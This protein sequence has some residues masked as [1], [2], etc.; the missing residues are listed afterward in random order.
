MHR[1]VLFAFLT[2]SI[3]VFGQNAGQIGNDQTVCYGSASQALSFT[4]QPSGGTIPYSYRWERSNDAGSHWY[5]ISGATGSRNVYSPPVLGRTAWFRCRVADANTV[6]LGVTNTVQITVLPDLTPGIIAGSQTMMYGEIPVPFY[7]YESASGGDAMYTYR[8]QISDNGQQWED[9]NGETGVEYAP[10]AMYGTRWFRRWVSDGSCGSVAGNS[11]MIGINPITLY[12]TETPVVSGNESVY[13]MGTEFAALRDG[14]ITRARLYTH[15]LE[16]GDHIVRIWMDD[17]QIGGYATIAGP[18]TWSITAGT[19]GWR[20]FELPQAVPVHAGTNYIV[21]ITNGTGNNWYVQSVDNFNTV[22]SNIYIDYLRGLYTSNPD[23]VPR[24]LSGGASFFRDVVFQLFTPGAVASDQSICYQTIPETL[25][26]TAPPEGGTGDYSYQWQVSPDSVTWTNID[27]AVAANYSPQALTATSYFR[28][29]ASSGNITAYSSPVLITV[30]QEFSLAQL[31]DDITIYNNT[32]TNFSIG[33]SGGTPPYTVAYDRNGSPQTPVTGYMSGEDIATG[34]LSTGSYTYS[35]TSVTDAAG[36]NATSTGSSITVTVSGTYVP[37]VTNKALV[38]VNSVSSDYDDYANY[39][40]PYL[41][42]FGV[43]AD[44]YNEPTPQNLPDLTDYA[45][46]ILGHRN[47]YDGVTVEYPVAQVTAAV[48]DGVGLVSFDPSFFNHTL[49]TLSSSITPVSVSSSTINVVNTSH[50]ITGYHASD[51]YN[52]PLVEGGSEYSNNYDVLTLNGAMS[53][54]QSTGLVGGTDL[55]TLS[56]SG[57]TASLVEVSGYGSGRIV[58]WN[59]Y[60]W[61]FE[62]VLGPVYGMDDI[63][64]RSIVWPARK[65]FVIKGM[66]PMITM[67]VDDVN[68]DG[69]GIS[70][71]F[72][73]LTISNEYGFVP[74]CGTFETIPAENMSLFRGLLN[75]NQATAAPHA[76]FYESSIYYNHDNVP[77]FDALQNTRDARAFYTTNALPMSKY[78][79]PHYYEIDPAALEGLVEMGIE[80]IGTHMQIGSPYGAAWLQAGPYRINRD[81]IGRSSDIMPVY[82]GGDLTYGGY[83]FFN[84]LTEI[85]D[86]DGYEWVPMEDDMTHTI[87]QGVRQ[88]TRSL[89]SMVLPVLFSHQFN[90]EAVSPA[91]WRTMLSGIISGI[92]K[93]N[94]EFRSMDYAVQ[95]IRARNNIEI[96]NV[97]DNGDLVNITYT[98]TNDMDTRCYLFTESGNQ[99]S[100]K[101]V[102]LPEISSGNVTVGVS[103]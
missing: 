60:D 93:F 27:G 46:V 59:D 55:A 58:K 10:Q 32:S 21:S 99:I 56:G 43:P 17:P 97:S 89:G 47:I 92:S 11:V 66:P 36:C 85:R 71:N 35:L 12:T 61:V 102:L 52:L 40:S 8:W 28:R 79:V 37:G 15:I 41:E 49:G 88:L 63:L 67:R 101:L 82:Y 30:N 31:H 54:S 26:E 81:Y 45:L 80:F 78:L 103:H 100:Y 68:G 42:N 19:Q 34:V 7:E 5:A 65:P 70:G 94:P 87:A 29:A 64:W 91:G 44:I 2:V 39:I 6:E 84:C 74:W 14:F 69:G 57:N 96:T 77:V 38:I 72:Q 53:V 22:A 1:L 25:T 23:Q 90:L 50:F 62:G 83:T 48:N 98:G 76:F 13:N 86:D 16:A 75:N 24:F 18:Y 4:V 51:A 3:S 20:E 33:I 9:L 73:W 95:Y